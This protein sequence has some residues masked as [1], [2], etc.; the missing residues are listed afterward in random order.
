LLFFC[1]KI[2]TIIYVILAAVED[3][4]T[5]K[6]GVVG[7]FYFTAHLGLVKDLHLRQ[8]NLFDWLP[9]RMVGGHFCSNDKRVTMLKALLMLVIGKDRR[10]RLRI[11]DGECILGVS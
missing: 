6:R 2:R 4:E 7:I 5:Q 3:E 10:V 8:S 11:H 9:V 1:G